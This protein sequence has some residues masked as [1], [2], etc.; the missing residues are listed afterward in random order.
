MNYL[1]YIHIRT[2]AKKTTNCTLIKLATVSNNVR[3]NGTQNMRRRTLTAISC[4][5]SPHGCYRNTFSRFQTDLPACT[6]WSKRPALSP[7]SGPTSLGLAMPQAAINRLTR[8]LR[9]WKTWTT[10]PQLTTVK[11]FDH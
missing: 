9:L 7:K 10:G 8:L 3:H 11:W 6:N 4:L 2:N 1:Q 5:V